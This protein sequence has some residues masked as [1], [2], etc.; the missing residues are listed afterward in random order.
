MT[1][2]EEAREEL[3]NKLYNQKTEEINIMEFIIIL[4]PMI[5]KE[6]QGVFTKKMGEITCPEDKFALIEEYKHYLIPD[7]KLN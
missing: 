2:A 7:N 4:F 3:K 5:T 6:E 1:T